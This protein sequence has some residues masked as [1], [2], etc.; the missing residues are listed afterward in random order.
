MRP[1]GFEHTTERIKMLYGRIADK[2][3]D[4]GTSACSRIHSVMEFPQLQ[5][6]RCR[7]SLRTKPTVVRRVRLPKYVILLGG[8]NKTENSHLL[9]RQSISFT[10]TRHRAL[11][12]K[13]DSA[14]QKESLSTEAC[15]KLCTFNDPAVRD[16]FN[17]CFHLQRRRSL[18]LFPPPSVSICKGR[19]WGSSYGCIPA[20]ENL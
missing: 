14:L 2:T 5:H 15:L 20:Q 9:P 7:F 10:P 19:R 4:M 8:V 6:I 13:E 11:R 17:D 3:A 16:S 1:V 12:L 18:L